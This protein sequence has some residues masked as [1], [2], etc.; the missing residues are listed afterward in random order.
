MPKSKND[1]WNNQSYNQHDV[2]TQMMKAI[3]DITTALTQMQNLMLSIIRLIDTD[4]YNNLVSPRN[5]A[6]E[7]EE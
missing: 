5:A 4:L 6:K 3:T 1:W 7:E 2:N